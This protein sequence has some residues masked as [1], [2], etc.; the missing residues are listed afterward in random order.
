M[1]AVALQMG[2]KTQLALI[3]AAWSTDTSGPK[4]DTD[5]GQHHESTSLCLKIERAGGSKAEI[6]SLVP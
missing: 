1:R 5:M 3:H 4:P 6:A 2:L